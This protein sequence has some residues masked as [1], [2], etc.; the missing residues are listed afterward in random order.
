MSATATAAARASA[1]AAASAA[2]SSVWAARL[3]LLRWASGWP[4]RLAAVALLAGRS[5][6]RAGEWRSEERLLRADLAVLPHSAFLLY[7][8]GHLTAEKAAL[9]AESTAVAALAKEAEEAYRA[10][11]AREPSFHDASAN[12]GLVSERNLFGRGVVFLCL[13]GIVSFGLR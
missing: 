5:A 11:L 3:S 6:R 12:L 9:A 1:S 10:A 7:E 2:A 4:W 13:S 8:W